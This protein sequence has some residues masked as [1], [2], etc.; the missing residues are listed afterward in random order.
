MALISC[1]ECAKKISSK[2][3][4]CPNCGFPIREHSAQNNIIVK[5]NEG[6]FLQTLN[7]GCLFFFIILVFLAIG[8][9][10]SMYSKK[11]GKEK[12]PV[13]I[14]NTSKQNKSQK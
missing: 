13:K 8:L 4:N 2:S 3:F 5:K 12:E 6:C 11:K 9:F 1:P 7:I 14:E 10:F